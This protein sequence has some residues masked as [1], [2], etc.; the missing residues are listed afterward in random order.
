MAHASVAGPPPELSK[1]QREEE[2]RALPGSELRRSFRPEPG[3]LVP[4]ERAM[5]RG[6]VSARRAD[7]IIRMS[8]TFGNLAGQA[9]PRLAE[10]GAALGL[11]LG[12]GL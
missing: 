11:W 6:Q 5:D 4:L 7:R 3:P 10:I 1:A 2:D 12:T 9:R 8:W